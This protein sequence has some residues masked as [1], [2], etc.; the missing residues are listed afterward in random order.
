MVTNDFPYHVA[1]KD[2]HIDTHDSCHDLDLTCCGQILNLTFK[3]QK[4]HVSIRFDE[5]NTM[6]TFLF[7][8]ICHI[9]QTNTE[10]ISVKNDNFSF[11]ALWS[12]NC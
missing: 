4:E 8:Y 3:V 1:T 11:D 9:K 10:N 5:A 7:S 6:M 12:Q 2:M